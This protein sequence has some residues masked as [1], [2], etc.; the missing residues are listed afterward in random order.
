MATATESTQ[1]S[2]WTHSQCGDCWFHEHGLAV[3]VRMRIQFRET[4]TCC[5]CGA[6]STDGIYVRHDPRGLKHCKGHADDE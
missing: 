1:V 6:I 2:A 4:E 3:P 5:F